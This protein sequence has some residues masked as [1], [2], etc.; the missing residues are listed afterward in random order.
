MGGNSKGNPGK[1]WVDWKELLKGPAG[2]FIPIMLSCSKRCA[3][4]GLPVPCFGL[5]ALIVRSHKDAKTAGRKFILVFEDPTDNNR[6]SQICCHDNNFVF[7]CSKSGK[8][9]SLKVLSFL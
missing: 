5:W 7:F 8:G 9:Q 2:L 3:C 1:R 4:S 6:R